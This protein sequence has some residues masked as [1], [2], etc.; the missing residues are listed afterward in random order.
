MSIAPGVKQM[1]VTVSQLQPREMASAI[2]TFEVTR[3]VILAPE[4]SSSFVVPTKMPRDVRVYLGTSPLIETRDPRIRSQA[5]K[6]FEEKTAAWEQVEVMYDWVREHV[7]YRDGKLKG[8]LAAL[9]DGYGDCEELS[10]LFIAFCRVNGIPARTVWVPGHC[11]PE[12]YLEDKEGQGHWFPCQ[13]AGTRDFG[14]I[15][16][17][18]PDPA[19]RGQLPRARR[20]EPLSAMSGNG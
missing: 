4:D 7:E 18:S 2:V 12:F 1:V 8:A 5:K 6:L 15:S 3:S 11:Y 13:A 19:E 9:K 16:E 10:S 17:F 14:G 20:E